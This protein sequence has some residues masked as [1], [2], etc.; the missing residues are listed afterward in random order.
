M[1]LRE[2]VFLIAMKD[3]IKLLKQNDVYKDIVTPS[4]DYK[5]SLVNYKKVKLEDGHYLYAFSEQK[6]VSEQV[7]IYTQKAVNKKKF[8]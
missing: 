8:S 3:N 5:D 4:K 2:E 6:I 7:I 1:G